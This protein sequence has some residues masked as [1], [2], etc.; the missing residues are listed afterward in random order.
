MSEQKTYFSSKIQ[1]IQA[2]PNG[3]IVMSSD[4]IFKE[5]PKTICIAYTLFSKA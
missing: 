2:T 3:G 4:T 5:Q 1:E